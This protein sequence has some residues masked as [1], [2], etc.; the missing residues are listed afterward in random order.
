MA[1]DETGRRQSRNLKRNAGTRLLVFATRPSGFHQVLN[2]KAWICAVRSRRLHAPEGMRYLAAMTVEQMIGLGIALFLMLAGTVG[3]LV[4]GIP[5]T[6]LV[7]GAAVAHRLWFGEDG[8]GWFALIV[9]VVITFVSLLLDH[10]ASMYGARKLG[11]TWRG[12]TGAVA[13]VMIGLFFGI[14]GVIL[15]PFIGALLLEWLGGR[16]FKASAKA[17]V[18]AVLGVFAGALGKTACCLAMMGVFFVSVVWNTIN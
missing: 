13:G 2:F 8:P 1:H 3:S 4:P 9:L 15:G 17:G 12:V 10:L 5:S 18:G 16:Q 11:A 14:A 6:P 7:L